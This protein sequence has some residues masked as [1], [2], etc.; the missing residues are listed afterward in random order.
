M[1]KYAFGVQK[2]SQ[3]IDFE[4]ER[5]AKVKMLSGMGMQKYTSGVQKVYK[6]KRFEREKYAKV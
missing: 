4:S 3:S 1:Q 6:T 5:Y 2:V